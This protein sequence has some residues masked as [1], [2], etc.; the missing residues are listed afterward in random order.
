MDQK[1]HK[2]QK[3]R[4]FWHWE[5]H[6]CLYSDLLQALKATLL[7][8][9][10]SQQGRLVFLCLQY[11]TVGQR[12]KNKN[13]SNNKMCEWSNVWMQCIW[14]QTFDHYCGRGPLVHCSHLRKHWALCSQKPLRL[15]RDREVGWLGIFISNA[16]LLHC[17]HQNES[18]LRWQLCEPFK[19]FINCVG[20]VTRQSP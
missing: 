8:F 15:I 13:N 3:E 12:Q 6:G 19:C 1:L 11:L 2:N 16:Y 10:G 9:L 7:T 18:A 4:N 17:H 20:K 14:A 5:N